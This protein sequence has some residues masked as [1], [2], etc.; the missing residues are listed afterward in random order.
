MDWCSCSCVTMDCFSVWSVLVLCLWRWTRAHPWP[1]SAGTL[2][3]CVVQHFVWKVQAASWARSYV[4][5]N[6]N[7]HNNSKMIKPNTVQFACQVCVC[8][9]P[10]MCAR[11]R[12]SARVPFLLGRPIRVWASW[13][14]G[15]APLYC[16][17]SGQPPLFCRVPEGPGVGVLCRKVRCHVHPGLRPRIVSVGH[18]IFLLAAPV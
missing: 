4:P 10:C 7:K 16:A 9:V 12:A 15:H 13:G 14:R 3:V 17:A 11:T 1:S 5:K 8:L 18:V 2:R 6:E